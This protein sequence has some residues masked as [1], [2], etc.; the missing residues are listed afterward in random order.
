MLH[1]KYDVVD[2]S[3]SSTNP[4]VD[5][6]LEHPILDGTKK[7]S[8]EVTEFTTPLSTEPPLPLIATFQGAPV[9]TMLLFRLRRKTDSVP[10]IHANNLLA[11]LP[12]NGAAPNIDNLGPVLGPLDTFT[13]DAY[14]PFRTPNDILFYLQEYFNEIKNVYAGSHHGLDAVSH[15]GVPNITA[16]A[17][18]ADDFVKVLLTPNGTIR[19]YF[20]E[21]FTKHFFLETSNYGVK[22]FGLNP[23]DNRV[24]AFRTVGGGPGGPVLT[25][26]N[27]L[28]GVPHG[29]VI[30]VGETSETVVLQCKYPLIRHF[31]HRV[32]LEIDSSAMPVPAVIDW[33]TDNRQ[34]V[35]HTIATFPINQRMETGIALNTQ[36]AHEGD[37][38]FSTKMFLGDI[39]FR[40]AED[41]VSERYEILNSQFFQNI[42]LEVFIV[43][44]EW[45][46]A[47]S[48]FGFK[49]RGI[50]L[51]DGESWTCK[52]R[53][54]TF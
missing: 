34:R 18:G 22:L 43:R 9:D 6:I 35:R 30:V 15:G 46:T 37:I 48:T 10:V 53:F 36:G 19:F 8:I 21:I 41:K 27:A 7:Y 14:R 5:A 16:A 50:T 51:A 47:T 49:R 29:V 1:T 44:K 33:G 54:R 3:V 39:V 23:N 2:V 42:R 20:S 26:L 28:Y 52:L 31:D 12:Q 45:N 24:V 32:R 11:N 40:R 13:H 4:I 38:S 17:M 25:G